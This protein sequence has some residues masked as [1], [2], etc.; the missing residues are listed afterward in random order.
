MDCR[1]YD[2]KV[3]IRENSVVS[4]P[5]NHFGDNDRSS[6][7]FGSVIRLVE[8]GNC[9][10]V[11]WNEDSTTSIEKVEDLALE[12]EIPPADKQKFQLRILPTAQDI[13][14]S[15]ADTSSPGIKNFIMYNHMPITRRVVHILLYVYQYV[16][17]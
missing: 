2:P 7:F 6:R 12:K 11:K 16:I 15:P 5:P 1:I 17:G 8:D 4:V 9:A 10:R 14:G 3:V 13:V